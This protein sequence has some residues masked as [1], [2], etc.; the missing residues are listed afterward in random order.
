MAMQYRMHQGLLK[1]IPN[2]R[3]HALKSKTFVGL[4]RATSV[5]CFAGITSSVFFSLPKEKQDFILT[6]AISLPKKK[7]VSNALSG[8]HEPTDYDADENPHTP[9]PDDEVNFQTL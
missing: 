1:L 6:S 5:T 4:A 2:I 7:N 8:H 3:R 9:T